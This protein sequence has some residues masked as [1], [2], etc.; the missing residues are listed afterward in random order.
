VNRFNVLYVRSSLDIGGVTKVIIELACELKARGNKV[1]VLSQGGPL[2]KELNEMSIKHCIAPLDPDRKSIVSFASSFFKILKIVKDEKID[3]IH[4]HHRWSTFIAYFVSRIVGIPLVTTHHGPLRGKKYL[5]F[6]GDR[7]ISVCESGKKHLASYFKVNP[8][9]ITVIYNGIELNNLPKKVQIQNVLKEMKL[10]SRY[11]IVGS[12][13]RLSPEKGQ[14]Y[15]LRAIR[16]VLKVRPRVQFVI[17][18]DGPLRDAL[19][20]LSTNMGLN[21]NVLFIGFRNDIRTILASLDFL[22][23]PSLQEGLPLTI[24]EAF[25]TS[26][27]VIATNVGGV[28]EAVINGKTGIL[29]PSRNHKALADA[30]ILLFN[31]EAMKI[32]MGK[33]GRNLLEQKFN[34]KEMIRKTEEVY[35]QLLNSKNK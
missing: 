9:K 11:P 6:W 1:I 10:D 7:V 25:A 16:E 2:V 32:E 17:V 15:L 28:S 26:K 14:K 13:A 22:V 4:S 23:L 21:K 35:R 31:N 33:R 19:E 5:S 30:M 24:L 12:I 3:I 8:N 27:P 20:K 34:L 29:V 18:G